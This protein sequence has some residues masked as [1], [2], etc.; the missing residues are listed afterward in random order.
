MPPRCK[1][2]PGQCSKCYRSYTDLLEH[3]NKRHQQ[4]R[5]QQDEVEEY[6]LLVCI[7][8]RVVRNVNGLAKHQSRFGCLGIGIGT[9]QQQVVPSTPSLA[10]I[11]DTSLSD[12]PTNTSSLTSLAT[13]LS[14]HRLRTSSALHPA[15]PSTPASTLTP[16][17]SSV[18]SPLANW[19]TTEINIQDD[20]A[21]DTPLGRPSSLPYVEDDSEEEETFEE[22]DGTGGERSQDV[23]MEDSQEISDRQMSEATRQGPSL[24]VS[25]M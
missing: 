1:S 4:D 8:G 18:Y 19:I 11:S 10:H 14:S 23:V 3:I 9:R 22:D 12:L 7:C 17:P 24:P 16:V 13:S 21:V 5:F 6:G 15:P 2:G 25:T 20:Q